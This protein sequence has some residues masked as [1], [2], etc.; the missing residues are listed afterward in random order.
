MKNSGDV[1]ILTL[2]LVAANIAAAY[3][4]VFQPLLALD[5]GFQAREPRILDAT[6][7]LFIHQN[8]LHLLGNMVFLA[9]VGKSVELAAG[10]LRFLAVYLLG[11]LAGVAAFWFFARQTADPAPLV[12]ASGCVAACIAYYNTRYTRLHVTVAPRFGVP[13]FAIT[14]LWLVLQVLG[15][16]VTLGGVA[17]GQSFWAHLGGFLAGLLLS[18]IFRAPNEANKQMGHITMDRLDD[19]SPAAKVA[20]SDLHL[21][22]H[23]EDVSALRKKA[24]ALA[25]MGDK[26]GEGEVLLALIE[27]LDESERPEVLARLIGIGQVQQISSLKRTLLADRLRM[28]HADL[29]RGLLLSVVGGDPDD[30]QRPEALL[31]L[32][33]M[34]EPPERDTWL[35]ELSERYAMHP[36]CELAR[37]RGML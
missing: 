27:C 26:E 18:A 30:G 8:V 4:V 13:I 33:G 14:V 11:G 3:L 36:A 9:A 10:R 35:R 1:P 7:S 19:R 31:A 6:A 2:S 23:P 32:A 12:G 22:D 24:S 21:A 15:A 5:Y 20:A 34:S 28:T 25:L 16:F 29:S 17:A 37:H